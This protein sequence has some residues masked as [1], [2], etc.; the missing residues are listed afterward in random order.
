MKLEIKVCRQLHVI[1]ID[2]HTFNAAAILFRFGSESLLPCQYEQPDPSH[3][4]NVS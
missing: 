3:E 2:I 4:D 1:H